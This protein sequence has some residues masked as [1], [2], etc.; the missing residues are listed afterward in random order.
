M[1]NVNDSC[2]PGNVAKGTDER[3]GP[4]GS[5]SRSLGPDMGDPR[6][7][8]LGLARHRRRRIGGAGEPELS[9]RLVDL[10][11]PEEQQPEVEPNGRLPREPAG[12]RTET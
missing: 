8:P 7:Q 4:I 1:A 2:V 6:Q 5:T 10:T 12:Q 3:H 11:R 9:A